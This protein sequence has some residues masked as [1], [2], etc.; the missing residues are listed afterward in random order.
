MVCAYTSRDMTYSGGVIRVGPWCPRPAI[1][2][3]RAVLTSDATPGLAL[4]LSRTSLPSPLHLH[5]SKR[6]LVI[7]LHAA[8]LAARPRP[9]EEVQ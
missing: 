5:P 4:R 3:G 6:G 1:C 9:G 7:T 8:Q 2:A